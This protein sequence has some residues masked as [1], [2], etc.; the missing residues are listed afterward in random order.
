METEFIKMFLLSPGDPVSRLRDQGKVTQAE[1]IFTNDTQQCR[2]WWILNGDIVS[3]EQVPKSQRV[4]FFVVVV[5]FFSPKSA[6]QRNQKPP[7]EWARLTDPHRKWLI[8]GLSSPSP[9]SLLSPQHSPP[10]TSCLRDVKFRVGWRFFGSSICL[11]ALLAILKFKDAKILH[12]SLQPC[13]FTCSRSE[14][15]ATRAWQTW[16]TLS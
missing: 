8:L 13:S 10:P 11:S 6:K 2:N 12:S 3:V 16:T 15:L 1:A 14:V 5:I 9:L 4:H 7:S